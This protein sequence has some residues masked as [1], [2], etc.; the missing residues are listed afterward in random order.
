MSGHC[1]CG[2]NPLFLRE[3]LGVRDS[4]LI[5]WYYIGAVDSVSQLFLSFSMWVFS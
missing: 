1:M 5:V 4:V 3:K 2:P